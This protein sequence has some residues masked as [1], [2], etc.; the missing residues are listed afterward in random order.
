[1][2]K[3]DTLVI[4]NVDIFSNTKPAGRRL[5]AIYYLVCVLCDNGEKNSTAMPGRL[6]RSDMSCVVDIDKG[7]SH[8]ITG[9]EVSDRE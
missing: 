6:N 9:H 8:P 3:Y 1:M 2:V 7:K 5:G 4:K